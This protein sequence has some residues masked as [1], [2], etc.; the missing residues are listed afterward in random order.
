MDEAYRTYEDG[1][2]Q[3]KKVQLPLDESWCPSRDALEWHWRDSGLSEP[4]P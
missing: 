2:F 1:Q 4:Q 3:G